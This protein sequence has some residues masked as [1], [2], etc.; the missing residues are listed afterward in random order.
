M[1]INLPEIYHCYEHIPLSNNEMFWTFYL[2]WFGK[3][4]R[5][6]WAIRK[7]INLYLS[8]FNSILHKEIANINMPG[9]SCTGIPPIILHTYLSLVIS[10]KNILLNLIS[11]WLHKHNHPQIKRN[12]ITSSYKFSL[13]W[14]VFIQLFL[15]GLEMKRSITRWNYSSCLSAH[16]WMYILWRINPCKQVYEIKNS[17]YPNIVHRLIQV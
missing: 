2:Q 7:L 3:I 4:I 14:K 13:S 8:L 5:N 12:I 16:V 17:N 1:K 11:L 9:I 6:H 10:K 15:T